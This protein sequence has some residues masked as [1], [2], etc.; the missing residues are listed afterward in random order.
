[1][2]VAGVK[3]AIF[4]CFM[5]VVMV[6]NLWIL[7]NTFDIFFVATR[8]LIRRLTKTKNE[9]LPPF[10]PTE[11]ILKRC[12]SLFAFVIELQLILWV[13]EWTGAFKA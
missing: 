4:L 2:S 1:M 8:R 12:F 11:P 5:I 7:K 6:V 3:Q 13:G 10:S 9:V